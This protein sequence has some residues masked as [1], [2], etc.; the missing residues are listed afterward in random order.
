[1]ASG[2]ASRAADGPCHRPPMAAGH[3][4]DPGF[5]G[6]DDGRARSPIGLLR[7]LP[8]R[9]AG[10]FAVSG[11]CDVTIGHRVDQVRSQGRLGHPREESVTTLSERIQGSRK[12]VNSTPSSSAETNASSKPAV[13]A[14]K[15]TPSARVRSRP[16]GQDAC[17][18]P[19]SGPCGAPPGQRFRANGL[20][21]RPPGD[22]KGPR[23]TIRSW[24]RP[25][26]EVGLVNVLR[27]AGHR[28]NADR[29]FIPDL[30]SRRAT[31]R[32]HVDISRSDQGVRT[33]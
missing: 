31:P 9:L 6:L 5:Q 24:T 32:T 17:P 28:D 21:P 15:A 2:T 11:G 3:R 22:G 14:R 26:H 25:A 20:P 16:A 10:R 30:G 19:C 1:M 13:W 8:R 33:H 18:L 23:G 4:G 7:S 12:A 27:G 29:A